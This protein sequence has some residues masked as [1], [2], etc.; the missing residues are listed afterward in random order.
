MQQRDTLTKEN[1][2]GLGAV[3]GVSVKDQPG[4]CSDLR[5]ARLLPLREALKLRL[6]RIDKRARSRGD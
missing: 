2:V 1:I 5:T 4:K 6:H 3:Q